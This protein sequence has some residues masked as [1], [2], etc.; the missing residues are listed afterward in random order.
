MPHLELNELLL[1]WRNASGILQNLERC[2]LYLGCLLFLLTS[3]SPAL[4]G[5]HGVSTRPVSPKIKSFMLG[6]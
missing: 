6:K 1:R 4:R 5:V 3:S 2:F